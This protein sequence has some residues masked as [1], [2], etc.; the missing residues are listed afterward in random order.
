MGTLVTIEVVEAE[1][2]PACDA[3]L[4]RALQWFHDIESCCSRFDRRSELM[5][6]SHHTGEAMH[7]SAT[8]FEAV[9][10]SLAMAEES[11][12]AFDPTLGAAMESLGFNRE[13]RTREIVASGVADDARVSY[14]DVHVDPEQRTITLRRP[15]L[16]DL[17]AVAKGLA[18]DMA[19][20]ELRPFANYAI[21]AGGDL[22][23]AGR[24]AA[25]APWRVG[26]RH[27]REDHAIIDAV[28]VSN[29]AVCTS[30]DYERAGDRGDT[31]ILD[32]RT[33]APARQAVSVTTVA[34]TAM[35]ADAAATAAYVLGP[36]DG[37][38]LLERL[39]VEGLM[40]TAALE[41]FMTR[42]FPGES[43]T[44]VLPDA[45]G[46]ADDR[47]PRSDRDRRAG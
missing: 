8:L 27:P 44:P 41:R 28:R 45:Q 32:P 17:G 29:K 36:A 35:L 5:R 30:G 40:I 9:R 24:N 3:A 38:A 20:H 16:L 19:A 42:G 6:L 15:L 2:S 26:V 18:V 34:E 37:I 1:L 43:G 39:N 10:F 14:R 46:A 12:G 23:L 13:H 4:S 7:A 11:G 22:Y 21:D 47:P 25:G 31:H 33:R